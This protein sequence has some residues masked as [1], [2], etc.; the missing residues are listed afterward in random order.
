MVRIIVQLN[1]WVAGLLLTLKKGAQVDWK[2]KLVDLNNILKKIV[3]LIPIKSSDPDKR[4]R[5]GFFKR[6]KRG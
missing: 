1:A 3:D 4:D 2:Q 5:G 6:R